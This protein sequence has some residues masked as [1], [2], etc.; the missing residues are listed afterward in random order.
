MTPRIPLSTRARCRGLIA[1]MMIVHAALLISGLRRNF[2]VV[3]EFGHIPAGVHHWR[4]G[5]FP[6]Y[7]VNPPLARMVAVLP[8]LAAGPATDFHHVDYQPGN[9][10]DWDVGRDF[11]A[12]NGDRYVD[13]VRLARL[14]GVAWSLL[15]AWLIGRWCRELYGEAAACVGVALWCFDPTVL[16]FARVV[17]PDLPSAVAAL[18]AVYAYWRHL[19]SGSWASAFLAGLLLGIA[20]LTKFT[21]VILYPVLPLIRLA[22]RRGPGTVKGW[23]GLSRDAVIVLVSVW[24]INL[25][26]GFDRSFWAVKDF[27]FCSRLLGGDAIRATDQSPQVGNRFWGT[28]LGELIV[29]VPAEYLRG[30]DAQ[31][32]DFEQGFRSYLGGQW[33]ERGWCYYYLYALAVKEPLGTLALVAWGL[34]LT[35]RRH[36]AAAH[37]ADELAVW[38][39]AAAVLVL[40]S[41]Q[42]GFNHHM[43]YV[44]PAFP[45]AAVA[46]GKLGYFLERGRMRTG[47]LVAAP[48]AWTIL[49]AISIHPHEMSYFNEAAGGPEHGSRH[50]LDSNIDWGQDFLDLKRWLDA[51]P[52]ASPIGMACYNIFDPA[53]LGIR[54]HLPPFGPEA[55]GSGEPAAAVGPLPGYYAISV[56]YLRGSRFA[57]PNG[58]GGMTNLPGPNAFAYFRR[59]RPIAR[60]GYSIFIYHIDREGANT[61]R[62]DLGLDPIPAEDAARPRPARPRRTEAGRF[63]HGPAVSRFRDTPYSQRPAGHS[64]YRKLPQ[65]PLLSARLEPART[66]GTDLPSR[67][68]P[69]LHEPPRPSRR[70]L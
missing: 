15:G 36:P 12:A 6:L 43:R 60:A 44:L 35:V 49:A 46:T 32:S 53:L 62:R 20:E 26:Y 57:A 5:Q 70:G 4:T 27:S 19:R 1:A 68:R 69:G 67:R 50:L 58:R 51:H 28:P 48:L 65:A 10:S 64:P 21:L 47:L 54:Y 30:I 9:R 37:P 34:A 18:A 61:V 11:A 40:V 16:A 25:G 45:F 41:S 39:P 66:D 14:P 23:G 56:N 63:H 22:H 59:F 2:V 8:M 33:R 31:R 3:D 17:V 38:L 24:V 13:L 55:R 29:P 42:T 52:E 7:R